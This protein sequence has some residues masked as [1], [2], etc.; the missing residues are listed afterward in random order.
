MVSQVFSPWRD[1]RVSLRA[2]IQHQR[3]KHP[4]HGAKGALADAGSAS[5]ILASSIVGSKGNVYAATKAVARSFAR[6]WT[7]DFKNRRIRVNAISPGSI[8]TPGLNDLLASSQ[9]GEERPQSDLRRLAGSTF[10]RC[11]PKQHRAHSL[12]VS[13]QLHHHC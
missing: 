5:I 6:T 1:N 9:T 4:F 13:L 8:D 3:E 10:M 11:A 12:L 7:T 2:N